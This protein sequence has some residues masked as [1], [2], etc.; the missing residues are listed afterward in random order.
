MHKVLIIEDDIAIGEVEVDYLEMSGFNAELITDGKLGLK[1]ALTEYYDL[2]IIDLM[3]PEINGY[4]I[5]KE[6]RQVKD[7]PIIMVTAKDEEV[8]KIRGFGLGIDDYI[9]KPFNPTE[10][11]TRVKAYIN[12]YEKLSMNTKQVQN[13]LKIRGLEIDLDSH[14]VM[15]NGEEVELTMK[16]F[17][18][19]VLLA[20]RPDKS[21]TK[22]EIFEKIWGLYSENDYSTIAVHIRRLRE[23]IEF[24]PSD[25]QYIL[26]SWG[27]GYKLKS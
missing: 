17:D 9:T 16:E 21:F 27:V 26:T 10:L 18:L 6:I 12:R 13:G 1:K 14:R 19:L 5:C 20:S 7:I 15:I 23:K 3:L 25:P 8:N 2:I 11:I 24:N 22:D 4:D